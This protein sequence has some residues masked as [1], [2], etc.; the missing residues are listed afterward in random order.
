MFV[1]HGGGCLRL[2]CRCSTTLRQLQ[3]QAALSESGALDNTHAELL[4]VFAGNRGP[5]YGSIP[6]LA[7][8]VCWLVTYPAAHKA[9]ATAGHGNAPELAALCVRPVV[10]QT[11]VHSDGFKRLLVLCVCSFAVCTACC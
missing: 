1:L 10:H 3:R 4:A 11:S 9:A 6:A 5:S 2:H 7:K 8:Q